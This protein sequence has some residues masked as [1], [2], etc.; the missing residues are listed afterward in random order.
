MC[1]SK[2]RHF[3]PISPLSLFLLLSFPNFKEERRR[4]RLRGE[5]VQPQ[6]AR[7]CTHVYPMDPDQTQPPALPCGSMPKR[8]C[9]CPNEHCFDCA[10]QCV[11]CDTEDP[12]LAVLS[13]EDLLTH[14]LQSVVGERRK[15][16]NLLDETKKHAGSIDVTAATTKRKE[17]EHA[18]D[19]LYPDR[20]LQLMLAK[21]VSCFWRRVCRKAL[22]DMEWHLAD[23]DCTLFNMMSCNHMTWRLPLRCTLHPKLYPYCDESSGF[24]D[25]ASGNTAEANPGNPCNSVLGTLCDLQVRAVDH[26][27]HG[28][29][30]VHME[31]EVDGFEGS[32][33]NVWNPLTSK[34]RI[35]RDDLHWGVGHHR[36]LEIDFITIGHVLK[37]RF[38]MELGTLCEVCV[39]ASHFH[40]EL[41][42]WRPEQLPAQILPTNIYGGH[43]GPGLLRKDG[44]PCIVR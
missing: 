39:D 2:V 4:N 12:M 22:T 44:S 40:S 26:A 28:L 38:W 31:L 7:V 27:Q 36:K 30:I 3:P 15:L 11:T 10:S 35:T 5:G 32:F 14:I 17:L 13:N 33:D 1:I 21:P 23:D 18:L 37:N 19:N 9:K 24:F 41:P 16:E 29:E 34:F 20:I 43:R 25:R 8:F 42:D 6:P